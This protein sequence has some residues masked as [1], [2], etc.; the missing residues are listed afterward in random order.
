[1]KIAFINDQANNT[2]MG[3]YV[4]NLT[5]ELKKMCEVNKLF[6]NYKN[7]SLENRTNDEFQIIAETNRLPLIDNKVL[8]WQRISDKISK[9]DIYHFTNQN[10]SFLLKKY[11]NRFFPSV[12]T[13]HDITPYIMPNNLWNYFSKLHAYSGLKFADKIIAISNSTRNDLIKYLSIPA[14]K[15]VVIHLG[16]TNNFCLRE[17]NDARKKLNLPLNKKF[18]LN[19]S[20]RYRRKNIKTAINVFNQIQKD[21]PDTMMIKIGSER[22]EN[23]R[24]VEQLGINDKFIH[25]PD[26]EP[27]QLPWY[28]NAADVFLFPS[29]YEGFGF[30][31][32]E[33]MASGCPVV[34]SNTSS[35]PE[36]IG[37]NVPMFDPM[38]VQEFKNAIIK[39]FTDKQYEQQL[40]E[41]GLKQAL[42][43]SWEKTAEETFKVYKSIT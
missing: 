39:I 6:L 14:E 2:G 31:V 8:F 36:I 1:M 18:I 30:P 20:A 19:V 43:F 17:K 15:I 37:D 22:E 41:K 28:Y 33:S 40:V 12:V 21:I 26:I 34:S 42:K 11:K 38:D 9:H 23:L 13:C 29:L 32:L 10:M 3:I 25:I 35:L 16:I 5:G 7:G 24:L 27:E 4:S